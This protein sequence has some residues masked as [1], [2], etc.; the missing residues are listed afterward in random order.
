MWPETP[1]TQVSQGAAF[2]AQD[3]ISNIRVCT[4]SRHCHGTKHGHSYTKPSDTKHDNEYTPGDNQHTAWNNFY[5]DR[6]DFHHA[7]RVDGNPSDYSARNHFHRQ[8]C[9][10]AGYAKRS[11]ECGICNRWDTGWKP[12]QHS[13]PDRHLDDCC[14]VHAFQ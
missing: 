9:G 14:A 12:G 3:F 10:D 11:G 2:Y 6:N 4:V 5:P 1:D 13:N 8:S 7:V